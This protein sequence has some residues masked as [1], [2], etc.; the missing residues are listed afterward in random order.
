MKIVITIP[1]LGLGGAE[2]VAAR[3]ANY[4]A[5]SHHVTLCTRSP[6]E[7][8][9]RL[10]PGVSR[11]RLEIPNRGRGVF[12]G[13]AKHLSYLRK[14]RRLFRELNP[15][16]IISF[17]NRNNVQTL[18]AAARRYPVIVSERNYPPANPI[19]T[20][21]GLLRRL[22]YPRAA[23]LVS[24]SKGTDSFFTWIPEE[25]RAVIHNPI[26]T[27]ATQ[28]PRPGLLNPSRH[29]FLAAGRL[30]AI[31]DYPTLIKA[32]L[33]IAR[34]FPDWD[35]VILGEGEERK[36]LEG[37]VEEEGLS[38]RLLLPGRV[39]TVGDFLREADVFVLSSLS[40][41]FPNVILEAQ[42][43]GTPVI[44]TDCPTGPKEIIES[45]RDGILVPVGDSEVLALAMERLAASDSLRRSLAEKASE[46]VTRYSEDQVFG[47]WD[48]L[49]ARLV[50]ESS[51]KGQ[52]RKRPFRRRSTEPGIQL[53][54]KDS[55]SARRPTN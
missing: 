24:V 39:T 43:A 16:C 2:G 33:R 4:L 47:T 50:S 36:A 3:L 25:R 13:V 32:F 8:F 19:G 14:L 53:D 28:R 52:R 48:T 51:R 17:T 1:S 44:S 29:Y 10:A 54:H 26:P 40:E 12:G 18:L 6:K 35:L 21:W 34:R 20:L 42:A 38:G 46:T 41:G 9:Y 15:D 55:G 7:D 22:T 31:K 23:M 11:R 45:G 30:H 27:A 5:T 49:I 37:V